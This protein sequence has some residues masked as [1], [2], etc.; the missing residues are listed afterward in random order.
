MT[1]HRTNQRGTLI[2]DRQF[3]GVGRLKRA[4][5][6]NDPKLHRLLDGMLLTLKQAGRVDIL[7]AIHSGALT[8]LEVWAC[9]RLGELERLPTAETMKGL[10]DALETWAR[11]AEAGTWHKA[12]RRYA[13]AAILRQTRKGATLADL[14][15][16]VRAYKAVAKGPAMFNRTRAAA[17]AFVRDTL[18]RSHPIYG[19]ILDV[20]VRKE[21]RRAGRPLAVEEVAALADQLGELGPCLWAMAVTGM[22]PG[23]YWGR[24]TVKPDRVLIYGTKRAGRV[25][26]VP[27][28]ADV[29]APRGSADGFRH[30]LAKVSPTVKPYDLRRTFANWMEEA[31]IPRTRRRMYLGHGIKDVTDLYERTDVERFLAEDGEKLRAKVGGRAPSARLKLA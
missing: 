26:A 8:P 28:V 31:G 22:G 25:R 15:P 10:K 17:L 19:Q 16:A 21:A 11:T 1:P 30:A 29:A 20:T 13:V 7:R 4:S 18:G 3:K 24:W 6:T 9:F 5:G 23:E 14:A 2:L 27:R 12:S